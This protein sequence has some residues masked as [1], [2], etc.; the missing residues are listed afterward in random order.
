M[1]DDYL[2]GAE[3]DESAGEIDFLLRATPTQRRE[4]WILIQ[5]TTTTGQQHSADKR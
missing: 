2:R 5:T 1:R 4:G 3:R